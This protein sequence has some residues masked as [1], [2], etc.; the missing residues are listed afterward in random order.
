MSVLH[1]CGHPVRASAKNCEIADNAIY[2]N[3]IWLCALNL[4]AVQAGL[5]NSP[6][7]IIGSELN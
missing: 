7:R 2:S 6:I 1:L 3:G 5:D 4:S